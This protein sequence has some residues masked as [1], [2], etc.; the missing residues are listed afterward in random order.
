MVFQSVVFLFG[1]FVQDTP[2]V[3][4]PKDTVH[5]IANV[6][7][8]SDSVIPKKRKKKKT[9]SVEK[10]IL[11]PSADTLIQNDAVFPVIEQEKVLYFGNIADTSKIISSPEMLMNDSRKIYFDIQQKRKTGK[12]FWIFFVMLIPL[13]SFIY[14]RLNFYNYLQ[15]LI[16]SFF[17]ITIAQQFYREQQPSSTLSSILLNLNF[18]LSFAMY[19]LL[20][21]DYFRFTLPYK[22]IK[23]WLV[24]CGILAA[25]YTFKNFILNLTAIFFPISS[26]VSF[27]KFNVLLFNKIMGILL[28]F[29]VPVMAFAKPFFVKGIIIFSLIMV[30]G[31]FAYR[32]FRGLIIAREYVLLNKFHFFLY[33]CTLEI[34]PA[35]ILVKLL[36]DW[37]TV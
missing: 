7:S 18:V 5:H 36:M 21:S 11:I 37:V 16:R 25:V 17:N 20:L 3:I 10:V 24:L 12:P 32:F 27:Y 13:L 6:A 22:D 19:L 1:F 34:A 30:G 8:S 2:V 33:L 29:I 4:Q 26:E 23:L 15:D 9:D 28:V 35:V 14:V 31:I